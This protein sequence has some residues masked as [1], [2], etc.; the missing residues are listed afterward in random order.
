MGRNGGTVAFI[1]GQDKPRNGRIRCVGFGMGDL[2]DELIGT[3]TIDIVGEP[4]LNR[5]N[6]M[7]S[8]EMHLRDAAP[9]QVDDDE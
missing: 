9:S 3:D 6:G 8:V 5:Y 1:V 7:M 4:V 2:A